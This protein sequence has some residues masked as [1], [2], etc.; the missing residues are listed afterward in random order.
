ML[1]SFRGA[2]GGRRVVLL[3]SLGCVLFT[4]HTFAQ[5][6]PNEGPKG[7][8]PTDTL[9]TGLRKVQAKVDA[10]GKVVINGWVQAQYQMADSAGESSFAGGAFPANVDNR[11][12]I[13]RARLKATYN[14]HLTQFVFQLNLSERG[15]NLTDLYGKVTEPWMKAFSLT[16]G[17][18]NRPFGYEIGYSSNQRESPERGRMSQLLFPN[19]RDLGAM[20]TFQMPKGKPLDFLKFEGGFFNGTGIPSPGGSV[21]DFDSKKDFI[22]RLRMDRT[23]QS[24]KIVYGLGV[25]YYNGGWRNGTSSVWKMDKDL[26][27]GLAFHR[28]TDTTNFGRIN[29][30]NCYGA[31]GQLSI[32][33]K[34]GVTT[35]RAEYIAG[36]QASGAGTNG[37]T[38]LSPNA[39]PTT[40]GYVRHFSGMYLYLVQNI[41]HSKWDFVAK[42]DVYDPNTKV[43]GDRIGQLVHAPDGQVFTATNGADIKYTTIGLGFLYKL[44]ANVKFTAYYDIV[45]NETTN[46]KNDAGAFTTAP[47]QQDLKD[48]VLT[49]RMQY[50]F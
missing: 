24:E 46:A 17:A 37:T 35:L 4:C 25:S 1:S 39:Q 49:L 23:S 26:Q 21:S 12:I 50:K 27:G 48:N 5:A 15:A 40:D 36:T 43:A 19:E 45:T 7:L 33:W 29:E 8:T 31:D 18:Q 47:Y 30:R 3:N 16:V 10:L 6:Q 28:Y 20:I 14:G 44:D 22:G 41:N 38:T 42:Y 9:A 32:D 11:F 13:R 34:A 2:L